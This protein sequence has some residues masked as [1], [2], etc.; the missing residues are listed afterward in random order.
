MYKDFYL[1]DFHAI[2]RVKPVIAPHRSALKRA[3]N[4]ESVFTASRS[5][6]GLMPNPVSGTLSGM[7]LSRLAGSSPCG[8]SSSSSVSSPAVTHVGDGVSGANMNSSGGNASGASSGGGGS[9]DQ[10]QSWISKGILVTC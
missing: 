8:N 10:V 3:T 7:R 9:L 6:Q 2:C 5:A 4:A 1:S